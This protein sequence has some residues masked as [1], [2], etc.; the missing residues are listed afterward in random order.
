MIVNKEEFRMLESYISDQSGFNI[1]NGKRDALYFSL[2]SRMKH[3]QHLHLQHYIDYLKYHPQ[4]HTEF[5]RLISLITINETRFFRN[6]SHFSALKNTILPEMIHTRCQPSSRQNLAIWSAGCSSGEEPYSIAMTLLD[7]LGPYHN[8]NID[9]LGTDIN[10]TVLNKAQTG[11][12]SKRS[13]RDAENKY[14]DRYFTV[15]NG[16]YRLDNSLMKMV[17]FTYHNLADPQYPFPQIGYWDIIFCRNVLIYFKME[18]IKRVVQQLYDRLV[19]GGYLFIGFSESLYSISKDF[20]LEQIGDTFIYRKKTKSVKRPSVSLEPSYKNAKPKPKPAP[21]DPKSSHKIYSRAAK[22]YEKEQ[23]ENTLKLMLEYIEERPFDTRGYLLAGK[24]LF[25]LGHLRKAA[26][27]F[28]NVVKLNPMITEAHYY[29]GIIAHQQKN[30]DNAIAHLKRAL[31][32]NSNFTMAHY[33]LASIYHTL[34]NQDKALRAYRNTIQSLKH[35]SD[36]E[37]LEHAGQLPAKSIIETC[38][39]NIHALKEF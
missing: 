26:M 36:S 13:V 22:F 20:V 38:K 3:T 10:D 7:A 17:R 32:T 37:T 19:E 12:Y 21:I 33:Y 14:I 4:G 15:H 11:I 16:E 9:I 23:Y 18:V 28:Q 30:T 25:E 39:R 31:Y 8:W 24:S 1:D 5:K 2:L 29:L 27:K 35:I 34:G 6:P